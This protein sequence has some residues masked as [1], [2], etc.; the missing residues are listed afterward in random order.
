MDKEAITRL[1]KEILQLKV[2]VA[3]IRALW[4]HRGSCLYVCMTLC[5]AYLIMASHY[6]ALP[7][8][9]IYIPTDSAIN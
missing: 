1:Q 9:S 8:H 3:S 7:M 4:G 6:I 2:K 5:G